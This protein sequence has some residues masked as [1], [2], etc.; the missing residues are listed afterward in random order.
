MRKVNWLLWGGFL[1]AIAAFVSYFV[2]FSRF[3]I[4]RDVP[5]ASFLLF[6]GAIAMLVAGWRRAPRKIVASIVTVLG[7]AIFGGFTFL[8]TVF[9]KQIPGAHN[10]PAIGQKAPDFAL[11]DA[12]NRPVSLSSTLAQ[13]NGVLLVFYRGYW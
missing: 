6:A 3:A 12:N 4:T 10:A 8:V 7:I 9:T 1:L 2:F 13:S 5:W 11:P